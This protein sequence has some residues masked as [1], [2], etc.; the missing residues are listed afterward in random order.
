MVS[1]AICVDN[2]FVRAVFCWSSLRIQPYVRV[3]HRSF[4][5]PPVVCVW[6]RPL[7]RLELPFNFDAGV[8]CTLSD[9]WL[10]QHITFL[11]SGRQRIPVRFLDLSC[12]HAFRRQRFE[13]CA[14]SRR[15][16]H[17][18]VMSITF[19]CR[20][21]PGVTSTPVSFYVTEHASCFK[22]KIKED[23]GS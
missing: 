10:R 23:F 19:R 18:C 12:R 21:V 14:K 9:Y 5:R 2:Y 8:N 7:C 1:T 13:L 15:T 20:H 16:E 3:K 6:P 4:I 22:S 11:S 17:C